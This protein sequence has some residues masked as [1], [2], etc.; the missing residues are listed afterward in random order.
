MH[1]LLSDVAEVAA[2]R[3]KE[4]EASGLNADPA[5]NDE[6]TAKVLA[7]RNKAFDL[8]RQELAYPNI[9]RLPTRTDMGNGVPPSGSGGLVLTTVGAVPTL[10]PLFSSLQ[11]AVGPDGDIRPITDDMLPPGVTTTYVLPDVTTSSEKGGR[12][13]T[14]GELF[15][16][17]RNLPPLQP[18]KA[19]KNTTKS[20][21]LTFYH[22]EL[23]EKSKY[24]SGTYFSQTMSAGH[25]LDYSNATPTMHAKTKQRERAQS[26]AGHKPS[27]VELEMSEM[28]ALFRG[29]FSS[30]APSK[31]D[32]AAVIPSRQVGR[33]WWTRVGQRSFN[34]LVESDIPDNDDG[35]EAVSESAMVADFDEERVKSVI[36]N[37][38]DAAIDPSLDEALGKKTDEAMQTD[39]LLEEI[40]GMIETLASFQRNRNL[41]LPTSQDRYST[42]P[43]NGDM[44]R[45]GGLTHQPTDEEMLMYET[46]KG[47][48]AVIIKSLPP[49]AVARLNSDKLADLSVSTKI[50]VRTDEYRGVMEEDEPARLAR[51]AAQ[52]AA[53]TSQRQPQQHRAPSVSS[54][55]PYPNQQY[56]GHFTPSARPIGNAQHFPQTPSRPQV[57]N[58]YQQRP[59]ATVSHPPQQHF[60]QQRPPSQ[61]R[62][63]GGHAYTP[64]L[65]KAQGPYGHSNMVPYGS[66]APPRMPQQPNYNMGAAASPTPRYQQGY[67]PG[68]QQPHQQLHPQH[69]QHPQHAQLPPQ[70]NQHPPHPPHPQHAPQVSQIVQHPPQHPQHPQQPAYAQYPNGQQMPRTMSPQV[71]P[72]HGYSQTPTP[73]QQHLQMARPQYGTPGIPP[74]SA[75]RPYGNSPQPGMMQ[76]GSRPTGPL[77][78]ATVMPEVQQRQVMEQARARADAEQRVS[79]HMGKVTQGEVVGLAGI[80]LGGSYDVNKIAA[81]KMQMG[82]NMAA[83]PRMP[84]HGGPSPVNGAGIPA[85]SPSPLSAQHAMPS[86]AAGQGF[87]PPT[88]A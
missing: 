88:T 22:P 20:N 85:P 61:Y 84:M 37:W 18:P 57:S 78:Y 29:A 52:A 49:F 7:F 38:D 35:D 31:D 73:P 6:A 24:R 36:D 48:L 66:P 65:A 10:R 17:P 41:T 54:A 62:P 2:A 81:A 75:Q 69:M 83:S 55:S 39:D 70:H 40:S 56:P 21:V 79:G 27:S 1:S 80:G 42:D 23:T 3:I 5:T 63:Q 44:L 30:F 33:V 43:V 16:S 45:N 87:K 74:N 86:P 46:L 13:P 26:L 47:S 77:G 8:Y 68:F 25:W 9:P 59:P 12:T 72:A 11:R 4:L 34:K 76:Q 82:S 60:S 15:P 19:P 14:L 64:Q 28:E 67:Q 32:S 58:M 53:N 51:Q 71:P 50:E